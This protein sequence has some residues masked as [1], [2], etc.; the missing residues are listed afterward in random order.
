M[1]ALVDKVKFTK[2][3]IQI[4]AKH[5]KVWAGKPVLAK[6][7]DVNELTTSPVYNGVLEN[8]KL[9]HQRERKCLPKTPRKEKGI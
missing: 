1:A 6:E 5:L 2:S 9:S 3:T 4:I 8:I 7:K